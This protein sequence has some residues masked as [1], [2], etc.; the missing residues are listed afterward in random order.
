MSKKKR[1][2]FNYL[3]DY[4]EITKKSWII[5]N[6]IE[7]FLISLILL[8]INFKLIIIVLPLYYMFNKRVIRNK[9]NSKNKQLQMGFSLFCIYYINNRPLL[10]NEMDSL[11]Q[12]KNLTNNKAVKF[13]V[14]KTIDYIFENNTIE[15]YKEGLKLLDKEIG[16]DLSNHFSILSSVFREQGINIAL[17]KKFKR[18]TYANF[19]KDVE[20]IIENKTNSFLAFVSIKFLFFIFYIFTM[21][22]FIFIALLLQM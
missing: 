10:A 21:M 8:M 9:V 1:K 14:H 4:L 12:S 15:G 16:S 22:A 7:M 5:K 18:K 13:K 6:V 17:L 19:D 11:I 20:I 2:E 3:L